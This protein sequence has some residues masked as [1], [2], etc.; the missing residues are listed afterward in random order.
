M[1]KICF[2]VVLPIICKDQSSLK[3]SSFQV[4]AL[5]NSGELGKA[6][7]DIVPL[8]IGLHKNIIQ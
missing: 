8:A 2:I 1:S 5:R 6:D 4:A 3:Q 7:V